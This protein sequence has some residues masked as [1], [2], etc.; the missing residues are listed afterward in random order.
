MKSYDGM[1]GLFDSRGS[2]ASVV[3]P[4]GCGATV[5][6]LGANEA[7]HMPG[8]SEGRA[9]RIEKGTCKCGVS[10]TIPVMEQK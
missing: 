8:V 4:G 1:L 5:A 2:T 6:N 3:C 9:S 7:I 10:Y